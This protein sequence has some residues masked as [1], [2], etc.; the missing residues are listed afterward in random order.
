MKYNVN[1]DKDRIEEA[2]ERRKKHYYR[3]KTDKIPFCF[4]LEGECNEAWIPGNP[5]TFGEMLDDPVKA[6]EGQVLS[7]QNQADHFP[8]SDWLPYFKTY[9]YGEGFIPSLLGAEQIRGDS[10]PPFQEQRLIHSIED[11]DQL[12]DEL[13]ENKG[14]G[15]IAKEGMQRMVEAFDGYVPVMITDHQSPYGIAT[16]LI[17][18]EELLMALYDEPEL[19]EKLLAYTTN[20]IKKTIQMVEGWI[21]KENLILNHNLPIPGYGGIAIWDD[22]ISIISPELHKEIIAPFNKE[23]FR[24]YGAGHLHTCGPS[25]P[26]FIDSIMD[27]SPRSIDGIILRGM[28][29]TR[30]DMLELCRIAADKD[31]VLCSSIDA[32]NESVPSGVGVEKGDKE[33]FLKMAEKRNLLWE[34]SGN[35]EEGKKYKEWIDSI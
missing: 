4:N 19:V 8:D 35:A 15:P 25:F 33:M 6:V 10:M 3:E 27:C 2:K 7:F 34:V 21:G 28:N 26:C 32:V 14:Y 20:M 23:L 17:D 13:D 12:P 31:I 29:R 5:Y 22:Y 1:F 9:L 30:E 11:I 16:K 18:N 24:E